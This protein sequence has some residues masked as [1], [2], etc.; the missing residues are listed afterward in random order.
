MTIALPTE[1]N[2]P[3][4]EG[5]LYRRI[6]L[7]GPRKIGKTTTGVDFTEQPLHIDTQGGSLN[8]GVRRVDCPDWTTFREIGAALAGGG[9]EN[10][11]GIIVDTIGDL[12]GFCQDYV[13]TAL[14]GSE[15]N[16]DKGEYRHYS[17]FEYGKGSSAVRDEFKLRVAKLCSLGLPVLFIAHE[18]E[19]EVS[20]RTGSINV[21]QPEIGIKNQRNWLTGFCDALLRAAVIDTAEGERRVIE[22]QPTPRTPELGARTPAGGQ[23][24]PAILDLDGQALTE[25]LSARVKQAKPEPVAA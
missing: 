22:T 4:L 15:N 6:L 13:V 19:K 23:P 25:A 24:L 9:I 11:T 12:A 21:F 18:D 16:M 17:E 7:Q 10:Y 14:G 5:L 1:P 8:Y 2:T 3:A 20:T